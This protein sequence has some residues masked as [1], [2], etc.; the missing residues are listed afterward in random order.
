MSL[1]YHCKEESSIYDMKTIDHY[2]PMEEL[3]VN[4][5]E[6]HQLVDDYLNYINVY[7]MQNK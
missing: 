2:Y 3:N 5:I 4:N 6:N 1:T 7:V